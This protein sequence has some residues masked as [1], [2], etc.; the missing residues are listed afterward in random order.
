MT[1]KDRLVSI[2]KII[3]E[4]EISNQEELTVELNN[5]GFDVSQATV[6]RDVNELNLIK[7]EG[8]QRKVKYIKCSI[9]NQDISQKIIELFKQVTVSFTAVNNLVVVKT[10]SGNGS[11]TGMAIDAMHFP[12][13]FGTI[14]GDDTLLIIAKTDSDAEN[15]IKTLKAL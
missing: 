13:I 15:I 9:Q 12:Q 8:K 7:G 3:E 11:A 14:A 1:K 2:L 4:K 6:S 5:M 10:L